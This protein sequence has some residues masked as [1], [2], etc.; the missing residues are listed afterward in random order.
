MSTPISQFIPS[1][2]SPLGIHTFVP[3]VC[4]NDTDHCRFF[5]LPLWQICQI[6]PLPSGDPLMLLLRSS[7]LKLSL[8]GPVLLCIG[9]CYFRFAF[10]FGNRCQFIVFYFLVLEFPLVGFVSI[11][12]FFVHFNEIFFF[13]SLSI[14]ATYPLKSL[15]ANSNIRVILRLVSID[16][17]FLLRLGHTFLILFISNDFELSAGHYPTVKTQDFVSF[18]QRMLVFLL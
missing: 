18:L 9:W 17:L 12:Y 11:F 3:Y 15:S 13:P 7:D 10:H 16:C 8:P 2:P 6:T 4:E 5:V 14:V 1:P